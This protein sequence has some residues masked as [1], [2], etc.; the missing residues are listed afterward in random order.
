M[1]LGVQA[2]I[3]RWLPS[4]ASG[5]EYKQLMND[6]S[7]DNE[8]ETH[9]LSSSNPRWWQSSKLAI[10]ISWS[11][12]FIFLVAM[13]TILHISAKSRVPP[14][15]QWINCGR[16]PKEAKARGCHFEPMMSA[17]MPDECYFEDLKDDQ[18]DIWETWDWYRDINATRKVP[19]DEMQKLRNGDYSVVFTTNPMA[20]DLHCLYTWRKV[21]TAV[22]RGSWFLDSRT[23][24]FDHS[25]HCAKGITKLLQEYKEYS[26][27][28]SVTVWPLLFHDC[29]PLRQP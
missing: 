26:E 16:S 21:T 1:S 4:S 15:V 13:I 2:F 11:V 29:I 17:W 22:E 6:Y 8:P 23:L 28:T 24:E 19:K 27:N 18:E 9:N 7:S 3:R 20:H 10:V 12:S 14:N 5:E 25:T